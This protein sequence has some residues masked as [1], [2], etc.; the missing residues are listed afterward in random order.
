M[1]F[2]TVNISMQKK[3]KTGFSPLYFQSPQYPAQIIHY[4]DLQQQIN[5]AIFF[6]IWM[7]ASSVSSFHA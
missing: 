4:P 3:S 2:S 5:L 6:L 7:D 1:D